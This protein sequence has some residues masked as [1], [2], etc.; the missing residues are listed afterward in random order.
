MRALF[1]DGDKKLIGVLDGGFNLS[2]TAGNAEINGTTLKATEYGDIAV[3]LKLGGKNFGT[4]V[5][6]VVPSIGDCS[7][8]IYNYG[9]WK[10]TITDI[11]PA[12]GFVRPVQMTDSDKETNGGWSDGNFM[13]V[14]PCRPL[15]L[16]DRK[17]LK[18]RASVI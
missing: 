10:A 16:P 17:A 4:T 11:S 18:T 12:E 1:Y 15:L 2:T 7:N 5:F 9:P 8:V 14:T 13:V 3:D 6:K